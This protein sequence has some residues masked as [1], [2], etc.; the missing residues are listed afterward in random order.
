MYVRSNSKFIASGNGIFVE[1][2]LAGDR[3]IKFSSGT[4]TTN[5]DRRFAVGIDNTEEED[6][7]FGSNFRVISYSDEGEYK[8]TP[9]SVN[10]ATDYVGINSS[11]PT[12][13]LHVD[14]D[15]MRLSGKRTISSS[16]E[17]G[18]QGE[19]CWDDNYWYVCVAENMWKRFPL[20]SW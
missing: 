3:T 13:P 8:D 9:L 15:T 2:D 18:E 7:D 4:Y 16:T 5:E 14:G 19:F 10:R 6:E 1:G 12:S 11:K 17:A 20:S